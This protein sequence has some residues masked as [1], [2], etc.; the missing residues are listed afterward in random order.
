[1]WVTCGPGERATLSFLLEEEG[2]LVHAVPPLGDAAGGPG[3]R[4]LAEQPGRL[5]CWVV[6]SVE[7]LLHLEAAAREAGTLERWRVLPLACA[8]SAVARV[9]RLSGFNVRAV[10]GQPALLARVVATQFDADAAVLLHA[11][12]DT[13]LREALLERDVPVT[14][15][16][17]S[18]RPPP[19]APWQ[20]LWHAPPD[21]VVFTSAAAVGRLEESVGVDA[22]ASWL[23]RVRCVAAAPSAGAALRELGQVVP[24]NGPSGDEAVVAH[25][26]SV[27]REVTP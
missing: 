26:V 19:E 22:L 1:V 13:A 21:A 9:A 16:V 10:E 27:L 12:G 25:T 5:G 18:R 14:A 11:E 8:G 23:G 2:L 4:A 24:A 20:A 17:A 7:S 6:D 15:V 3:L